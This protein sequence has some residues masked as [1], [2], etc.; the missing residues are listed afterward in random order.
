MSLKLSKIKDGKVEFGR[1]H[2]R[3]FIR[4]NGL[5]FRE[6]DIE[7]GSPKELQRRVARNI[8]DAGYNIVEDG[9]EA[10]KGGWGESIGDISGRIIAHRD[11]Q[12]QHALRFTTSPYQSLGFLGMLA[13]ILICFIGFFGE[14][15]PSSLVI[16]ISAFGFIACFSMV[17][18]QQNHLASVYT[19]AVL[20][21]RTEGEAIETRTDEEAAGKRVARTLVSARMSV[22]M[23]VELLM[24]FN[25]SEVPS[26][27]FNSVISDAMPFLTEDGKNRLDILRQRATD[28]L[29]ETAERIGRFSQVQ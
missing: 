26:Q 6:V 14:N 9:M 23:N 27:F 12:V 28:D 24:A 5:K 10:Q 17:R 18:F 25:P 16:G 20:R 1:D 21:I 19:S 22:A 7:S 15:G 3:S 11:E 4:A 2:T 13:M 29:S 8:E